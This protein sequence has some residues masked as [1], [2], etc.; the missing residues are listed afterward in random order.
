[1]FDLDRSETG[2]NL[3]LRKV[4]VADDE[5]AAMFVDEV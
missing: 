5:L 2:H 4:T 1:L 3:P